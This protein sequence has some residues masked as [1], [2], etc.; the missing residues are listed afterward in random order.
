MC[1]VH[2][3]AAPCAPPRRRG[4]R[5]LVA[6]AAAFLGITGT[7]AAA[8]VERDLHYGPEP[9]QVL[10]LY[11]PAGPAASDRTAVVLIHG[12]AWSGSGKRVYDRSGGGSVAPRVARRLAGQGFV[13]AAIDYTHANIPAQLRDVGRALRWVRSRAR[14]LR[15]DPGKVVAW[16]DSAGGHLALLAAARGRA[17]AAV[18]WSAPTD[19]RSFEGRLPLG[20]L[21]HCIRCPVSIC[22]KR[23]DALSPLT[24]VDRIRVPVLLVHTR[25]DP[26][27]RLAE[28]AL[29]LWEASRGH[30][31]LEILP[32]DGHA[33]MPEAFDPSVRFLHRLRA[34]P[35]R[36]PQRSSEVPRPS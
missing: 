10:D 35:A 31:A 8:P 6:A 2:T 28:S 30:V 36:A 15:I 17:D 9:S 5:A 14:G 32:G 21:E 29:P 3:H 16:G 4:L 27:V 34:E 20:Y 25:A 1:P 12:G 22:P 23:W 7:L 11:R 18:A 26:L 13:V 24:Q 33:Y 19:L